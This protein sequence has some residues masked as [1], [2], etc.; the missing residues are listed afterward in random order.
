MARIQ[1]SKSQFRKKTCQFC[2]TL[3]VPP[4]ATSKYC[5]YPCYWAAKRTRKPYPCAVCGK[6]FLTHHTNQLYCSAQCRGFARRTRL[7]RTCP[8]CQTSFYTIPARVEDERG[9][10]CSKPCQNEAR[11]IPNP[12]AHF[13]SQV[14]MSGGPN[15][16]W[17]WMGKRKR[18]RGYAYTKY[19]GKDRRVHRVAYELTHGSIPAKK[20]IRHTCHNRPCCNGRHLQT[21]SHRQNMRDMVEAGRS[22]RG[23]RHPRAKLTDALVRKIRELLPTPMKRRHIARKLGVADYFVYNVAYR[24]GWKHVV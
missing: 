21:G 16:C 5:S 11:R 22:L 8:T 7:E 10:Y 4:Q 9:K 23:E 3:F 24:N 18:V 13:W 19:R 17:P 14:D 2:R 6:L 12:I 20:L 15:A 1:S